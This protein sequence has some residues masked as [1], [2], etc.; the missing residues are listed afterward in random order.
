MDTYENYPVTGTVHESIYDLLNSNPHIQKEPAIVYLINW[1]YGFVSALT[2][3]IQNAIF[4]NKIN[5][6]IIVLPHYSNNTRHFKYHDERLINSFFKYFKYNNNVDM[7]CK[8]YFAKAV[9]IGD[10]PLMS[11]HIPVMSNAINK[12][13]VTFFSKNYTPILNDDVKKYM[14]SIK[15]KGN[16]LI[17]IHIR[18]ISQKLIE[19]IDY[20]NVDL[21][22]RLTI[23]HRKITKNHPNA[24]IFIA[25][26]V[27]LYINTTIDLFGKINY[28]DYIKRIYNEGDSIPQLDKYKGLLLGSNIMDDCYALSL[29]DKVY[30]SKS[31]IPFMITILNEKMQMEDY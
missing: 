12:E 23:L 20:L 25:T 21:E 18:S 9:V 30:V 16:D 15:Q 19:T 26:D 8:K 11:Y 6:N 1:P 17:G 31:N 28:L 3:F 4:L 29:C 7:S 24:V 5:S 27:E 13:S 10:Y 22:T 14:N 2:V